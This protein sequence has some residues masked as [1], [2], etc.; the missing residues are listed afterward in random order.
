MRRMGRSGKVWGCA[1]AALVVG[2]GGCAKPTERLQGERS[3]VVV[4]F[5][6]DT[7]EA[8][9]SAAVEPRAALSAAEVTLRDRGYTVTRRERTDESG[10]VRGKAPGGGVLDTFDSVTVEAKRSGDWT[11]LRVK[12]FPGDEAQQRLIMDGVLALVGY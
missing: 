9:V 12:A 4:R 3:P 7:A 1:A 6:F 10:E 5:S 2:L 11:R 8:W